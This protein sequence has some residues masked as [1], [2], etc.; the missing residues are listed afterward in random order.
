MNSSLCNICKKLV[1]SDRVE[2]DGKVYLVKKCD[3]C[4]PNETLI[5]N[6]AVR[7]AQKRTLDVEV[8]HSYEGCDLKCF[9]CQRHQALK[10]TFVYVTNHCNLNCPI[11]FDNVPGLGFDFE[12]PMEYF[13]T[14]FKHLSQMPK[15]PIVILFGGEPTTRK[16]LFDIIKLSRSYGLTTRIFTNGL[17]LADE[18]FCREL[19]KTRVG[20]NFSY[21]GGNPETYRVIRGNVKAMELKQKALDNIAKNADLLH[22][23]M[24]L[25]VVFAKGLN[26]TEIPEI[27]KF[28][29]DRRDIITTAFLMPMIH[30]WD[31]AKWDYDPPRMTT[32]DIENLVEKA[33]PGY[34]VEFLPLGVVHEFAAVLTSVGKDTNVYAGAHPNCESIYQLFSDGEQWR[35]L[36]HYL[37]TSE[38]KI[39]KALLLMNKRHKE[40]EQRWQ[41]SLGGRVLG[42]IRLRKAALGAIGATEMGALL[43]RHVRFA[44]LI[45]GW[46]PAKLYHAVMAPLELM[47]GCKSGNVRRRHLNG[48]EELRLVVLPLEDNS[49]LETER[50]ER[51]PTGHVYFDPRKKK[52][53]FVPV[54]AWKLHNK[55]ALR[56]IADY[57]AQ[58]A[59]QHVTSDK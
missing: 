52:M 23:K 29:H 44:R 22:K 35:P 28:C 55:E 56:D 51:C 33:F 26:D 43:L 34:H 9:S 58:K 5:S 40:R 45:K 48:Q 10:F 57:Y 30:T 6:D 39:A 24:I 19:L 54:C 49:V 50:L 11:C 32:E 12:P 14:I 13:D 25:T 46:G 1:P 42:A 47:V 21:D 37:R 31:N 59:E 17:K 38:S 27:L 53:V 2:R 7:S 3:A 15:P 8:A 16:D 4:G 41:R 20:I 18:E 36:G